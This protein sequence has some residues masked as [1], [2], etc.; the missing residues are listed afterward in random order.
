[1]VG[2]DASSKSAFLFQ[3]SLK[4]GQLLSIH[5]ALRWSEVDYFP[6]QD[7]VV[8]EGI[9]VSLVSDSNSNSKHDTATCLEF[10]ERHLQELTRQIAGKVSG[11]S[12]CTL[13]IVNIWAYVDIYYVYICVC[14]CLFRYI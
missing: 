4:Q 7:A 9:P 14:T 2:P 12:Y 11:R 6:L 1:M 10:N 3:L 5:F 13:Y 8:K